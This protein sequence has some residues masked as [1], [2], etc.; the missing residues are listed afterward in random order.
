MPFLAPLGLLGLLA[1]PV[2]VAL[3]VLRLRR[4]ERSVS[5]TYL[6][7]QLVRDVEANAPWQRLRR[8]LLLLLQLLLAA[9]LALVVARPFAE[10]PTGLSR[11]LV[12]VVDASASMRAT[13]EFPDRMTAAKRAAVAA[14]DELPAD[15]RV[16]I[17]AAGAAAR[18]V[19]NEVT[20]RGRAARL[21]EEIQPATTAADMV[22]ALT[23][24]GAL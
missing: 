9:A 1:I 5:S 17:V 24:A 3:Y 11:D 6:W 4:D 8:S 20:A 14:L 18:V 12:L 2:I 22:E 10:R 19:G 7:Q 21:I 13:D 23:L 15:G 16:S